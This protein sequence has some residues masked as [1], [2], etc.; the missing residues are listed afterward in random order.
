MASSDHIKEAVNK[1]LTIFQEKNLEKVAHAVFRGK[2][3][4]ADK[5]SFLNRVLMYLNDT[6]DARG[7]RQWQEVGRYVKKGSKAFYIIGPVIKK[8]KEENEEKQILAGFKAIPVFRIE[9][10]EGEPIIRE[11]FK[12]NIPCEF[13][14]IIQELGLKIQP[15]RFCGSSYGSYNLLNKNINLASPDIEVFLHELSHAVDDRLNGL[16]PG[17]NKDQ[18]VTAEFSAAVIA[19]LMGYKIPLGNVREYVEHYSFKELMG[20]LSRIEK[21]VNYV[22][23]RTKIETGINQ[24]VIS[25]MQQEAVTA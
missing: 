15:V 21:I 20:C 12:V 7:F 3:I 18:E 2:D 4:P 19:H 10:T 5:W 9:N 22:I 24:P 25:I 11:E 8:I 13:N 6:E 1:L 17:Q 23:D 14:S 16:K